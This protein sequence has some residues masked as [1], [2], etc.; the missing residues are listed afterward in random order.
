ME[1]QE[2]DVAR[3]VQLAPAQLAQRDDRVAVGTGEREAGVGD[4]ADLGDDVL[5]RRAV[6][7]AGRDPEHRP[8]A[9]PPE[10]G[11]GAVRRHVA[12]ELGPQGLPPA[13]GDV[14]Q[15]PDLLGVADEQV[16]RCGGEPEQP[17][18]DGQDLGAAQELARSGVVAHPGEG[19][20]RELGSGASENVLPRISGV[21]TT[22][23]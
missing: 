8:A 5:E 18:G 21:S 19:D 23:S 4:V 20:A 22:A 7:V 9:E 3:V 15:R 6:E 12:A 1:Q 13:R 17:G 2:V 10:A 14:R 11:A 16:T